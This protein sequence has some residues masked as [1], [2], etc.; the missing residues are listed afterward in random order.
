MG[1]HYSAGRGIRSVR[2]AVAPSIL[3][4]L[5]RRR[6]PSPDRSTRRQSLRKSTSAGYWDRLR[7][8]VG[9][10]AVL[11]RLRPRAEPIESVHGDPLHVSC[12]SHAWKS[13][14]GV[15]GWRESRDFVFIDD[16]V[17][18]TC[19]ALLHT[20]GQPHGLVLNV[21]TGISVSILDLARTLVRIGG[22]DVPVHVTGGYRVGDVRHAFADTQRAKRVLGFAAATPLEEGLR[23][24]LAWAEGR[25]DH[26]ATDAAREYLAARGLY[27]TAQS[28]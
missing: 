19:R 13:N 27:R 15:R 18:A 20:E 6:G 8:V 28:G 21:G 9:D 2:S 3:F 26:D 7:I 23:R 24:W 4:R 1:S 25:D 17:E 16:V 5:M 22:W 10:P 14:R 11:Q 12:S